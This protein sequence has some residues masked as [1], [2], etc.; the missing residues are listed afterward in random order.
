MKKE[1]KTKRREQRIKEIRQEMKE[2]V[3]LNKGVQ[4]T[5]RS[6]NLQTGIRCT[7]YQ[8]SSLSYRSARCFTRHV[9]EYFVQCPGAQLRN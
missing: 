4:E 8:A 3:E 2:A 9:R 5:C 6:R 1:R 7:A